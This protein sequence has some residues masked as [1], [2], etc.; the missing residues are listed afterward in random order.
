VNE[1]QRRV[2]DLLHHAVASLDPADRDERI[3]DCQ[4]H[5][6]HGVRMY[7]GTN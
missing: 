4:A 5:N 1:L 6:E 2:A 3:A 7:P